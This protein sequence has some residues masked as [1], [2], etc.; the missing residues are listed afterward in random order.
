M[1]YI[2][3]YDFKLLRNPKFKWCNAFLLLLSILKSGN[4]N[5]RFIDSTCFLELVLPTVIVKLFLVTKSLWHI[6]TKYLPFT[7]KKWQVSI[8]CF[9]SSQNLWHSDS[10]LIQSRIYWTSPTQCRC[11]VQLLIKE[12][13]GK[14]MCDK[15]EI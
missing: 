10:T 5:P 8:N 6:I 3:M 9:T 11:N 2:S 4:Q 1:L 14:D 13:F 7:L 12:N 15:F